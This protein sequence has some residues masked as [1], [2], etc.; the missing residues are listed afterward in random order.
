MCSKLLSPIYVEGNVAV[1]STNTQPSKVR[2]LCL[3]AACQQG[4]MIQADVNK[5]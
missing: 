3:Q 5:T 1:D 2:S 4:V